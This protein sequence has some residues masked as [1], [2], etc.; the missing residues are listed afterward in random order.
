MEKHCPFM[1]DTCKEDK[2][3]LWVEFNNINSGCAI[4]AIPIFL[5]RDLKEVSNKM[6]LMLK[7]MSV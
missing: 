4:Q 7:A 3:Q 5:T 1:N 6:D 2:C